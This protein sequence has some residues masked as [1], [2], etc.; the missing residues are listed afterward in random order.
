MTFHKGWTLGAMLAIVA[1][2]LAAFHEPGWSFEDNFGVGNLGGFSGRVDYYAPQSPWGFWANFDDLDF[3]DNFAPGGPGDTSTW[4]SFSVGGTY[5][6]DNGLELD[7]SWWSTR[8]EVKNVGTI[9]VEDDGF[10]LRLIYGQHFGGEVANEENGW[11]KLSAGVLFYEGDAFGGTWERDGSCFTLNAQ[12]RVPLGTTWGSY[13][14]YDLGCE[15]DD[16]SGLPDTA[17][18][19]YPQRYELGVTYPIS[20][21]WQFFAGWEHILWEFGDFWSWGFDEGTDGLKLGLI[22]DSGLLNGGY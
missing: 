7:A 12:L 19:V 1:A 5:M 18:S 8:L 10:G 2:P 17:A 14:R 3:D 22:F 16:Y 9:D 20:P 21:G 11:W 6:W 13:G 15:S 4:D